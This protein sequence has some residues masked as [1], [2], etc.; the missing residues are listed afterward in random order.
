[1]PLAPLL[2]GGV[3]RRVPATVRV[4]T[5]TP[6]GPEAIDGRLAQRGRYAR[7]GLA[8]GYASTARSRP[9]VSPC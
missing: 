9:R 4:R 2:F 5:R 3:L 1:M 7:A 6:T 8:E